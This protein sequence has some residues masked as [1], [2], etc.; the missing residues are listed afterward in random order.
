MVRL[1]GI[2]DG[3]FQYLKF[4]TNDLLTINCSNKGIPPTNNLHGMPK[5]DVYIKCNLINNSSYLIPLSVKQSIKYLSLNIA[6]RI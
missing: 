2:V 3:L 4:T 6:Y 5:T 1:K